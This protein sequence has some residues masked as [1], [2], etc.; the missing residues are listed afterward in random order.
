MNELKQKVAEFVLHALGAHR[1]IGVGTGSTV[2]YFIEAMAI[3]RAEVLACIASSRAS[4]ILLRQHGFHVVELNEIKELPLYIDGADEVT[5]TGQM[6]KGAGGALTREKIIASAA[7]EFICIVDESKFVKQLG[8]FPLAVEVL[9][10][11]ERYVTACLSDLGASISL[12]Q[13]FLSDN[14][15]VILDVRGLDFSNPLLLEQTINMIPGVIDCGVFA[16][17]PANW[18]FIGKKDEVQSID[19]H[20]V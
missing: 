8:F 12:R 7:E 19:C 1:V 9:P 11:A 18:V 3:H 4:E 15:G 13:G 14:G 20:S 2:N 6:I 16:K 17:R 10:M 5:S